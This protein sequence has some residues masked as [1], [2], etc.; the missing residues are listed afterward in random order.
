MKICVIG[1]GYVGLVAG[2]CFAN[3]GNTVYGIDVDVEKIEKLKNGTIPIYEPGLAEMV[4]NNLDKKR[5][6]FSTSIKDGVENADIIFIA[7]GTPEDEDGSADL[8]YVLSAARSIAKHMKGYKIIV[9]KSTVPVG[10]ADKVRETVAEIT[11]YPFDIVSNPEFLKEGA[12][13]DDFLKPDRIIVGAESRKA[14]DTMI[15]LYTPF[16][17]KR[18]RLIIMDNRSAEMTKY[19]ANA[20][21]A[22]RISFMNDLSILAEKVGADIEAIR[23]GIGSDSRIGISFLFPG[24]GYGGSCFPKDVK[25]IL[26]TGDKYGHHLRIVDA[27]EQ[28]NRSQPLHLLDKITSHFGSDLSGRHFAVWGLSFKP[29]TDDMREAPVIP[30]IR[31][32]IQNGATVT[33]YDPVAIE[34][35]KRK[36]GNLPGLSYAE[37]AYETLEDAD[38]LVL[39]TEWMEF[40]KPDLQKVA[41]TLKKPVIFDGRNLFKLEKMKEMGFSYYSIGR[42]VVIAE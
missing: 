27:V 41:E 31:E 19:A 2:T 4:K 21:L 18:E 33:A 25:A 24:V 20:M 22:T 23:K 10:T 38:A 16:V 29:N 12:A 14:I 15:D 35:A 1:T 11:S 17:R 30:V 42:P 39:M 3:S 13:V 28:V 8:S 40:R 26:K 9:N 37:N 6:I 36:F 5:L 7:V 34:N 32:L